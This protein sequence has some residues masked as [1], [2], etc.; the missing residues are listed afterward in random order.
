MIEEE[1][2]ILALI[3]N[4]EKP[5][6][7]ALSSRF[8]LFREPIIKLRQVVRTLTNS[9]HPRIRYTKSTDFYP[10]IVARHQSLLM[11]KLGDSNPVLQKNKIQN[12]KMACN[13]LNG[14]II[15]PGNI[16]SMWNIIGEPTYEKGYI[17]GML[18]SNGKVVEGIGGGL[19]QLSNFLCWIFL[20]APT[21]IIERYH[22]SMD[23]FPD[24]GRTLPFGSGATCLY[25]FVDLKVQNISPYPLQL[26]IWVTDTHLK[27]QVMSPQKISSKFSVY[28]KRHFFVKRGIKYFRYNEIW[29]KEKIEGREINDQ[30]IFTNFAPVLYKIPSNYFKKNGYRLVDFSE[31]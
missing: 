27:G 15:A 9:L 24:S 12:L 5:S 13:N 7:R 25:N 6:R 30:K 2:D 21:R 1:L 22:H 8:P 16:F 23:V 3:K 18:L 28:Q 17:D 4:L 26:K 20:H 29:R 14:V 11:R 31:Q 19:C 10:I